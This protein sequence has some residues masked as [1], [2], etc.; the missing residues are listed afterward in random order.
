MD[1]T[2]AH[3]QEIAEKGSRRVLAGQLRLLQAR[4]AEVEDLRRRGGGPDDGL[5]NDL[6]GIRFVLRAALLAGGLTGAW[7]EKVERSEREARDLFRRTV[8]GTGGAGDGAP[9]RQP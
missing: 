2:A 8:A 4:K 7:R 1:R 6:A 9:G 5:A 3:R